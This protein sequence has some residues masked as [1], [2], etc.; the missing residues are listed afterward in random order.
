V[1]PKD[2]YKEWEKRFQVGR[3]E[4]ESKKWKVASCELKDREQ[5][6]QT[7][8]DEIEQEI[9][10]VGATAIE[11]RLQNDVGETEKDLNERGKRWNNLFSEENWDQ[12][13]GADWRQNRD[14]NKHRICL[15]VAER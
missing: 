6:M 3:G 12:D 7:L 14:S 15:P 10:I 5:F 8:M 9:E 11:D 4:G 2:D 13:M 1:I